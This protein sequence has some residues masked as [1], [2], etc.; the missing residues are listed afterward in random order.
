MQKSIKRIH[1]IFANLSFLYQQPDWRTMRLTRFRLCFWLMRARARTHRHSLNLCKRSSCNATCCYFYV[2]LYNQS[3]LFIVALAVTLWKLKQ[4]F[5]TWATWV[6]PA[7]S[8]TNWLKRFA[9]AYECATLFA[10]V[11]THCTERSLNRC[12]FCVCI[13]VATRHVRT[14]YFRVVR[15]TILQRQSASFIAFTRPSTKL[16]KMPLKVE[17]DNIELKTER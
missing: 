13:L 5:K 14:L 16:A 6:A 9:C 3:L 15:F 12:N 8:L 1:V 4:K 11:F 2:F 17:L 10:R 7:R